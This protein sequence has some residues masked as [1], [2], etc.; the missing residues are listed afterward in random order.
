MQMMEIGRFTVLHEAELAAA[1]L[2]S[3]GFHAEVADRTLATIDP[4]VQRAIGLRVMAPAQ[5]AD[6]AKALLVRASAGEFRDADAEDEAAQRR[7]VLS[8]GVLAAFAVMGP[9]GALAVSGAKRPMA[10]VRVIGLALLLAWLL[11]AVWVWFGSPG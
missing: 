7:T 2:R 11:L 6:E 9:P 10:V 3:R 1:F 5:E 8:L 4:L